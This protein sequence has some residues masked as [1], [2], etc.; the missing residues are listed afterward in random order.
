MQSPLFPTV[1]ECRRFATD[2]YEASMPLRLV[3]DYELDFNL[4]DGRVAIIDGE[5]F[6]LRASSVVLRRP[7]QLAASRGVYNMY[8]LTLGFSG[9]SAQGYSRQTGQTPRERCDFPLLDAIPTYLEPTHASELSAIY[10][11]ILRAFG[12][13]GRERECSILAGELLCLLA[14][15]SLASRTELRDES[16]PIDRIIGYIGEHYAEPVALDDLAGLVHMNK[17][18]LTRL[19]RTRCGRTPIDY[20]IDVRIHSAMKLLEQSSLSVA[21]IAAMSGFSGASYFIERFRR[22]VGVTPAE[23]RRKALT[24]VASR[25][26]I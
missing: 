23:Y 21:R 13:R 22:E 6:T 25:D 20:L 2:L 10:R 17:S 15:D 4:S 24:N 18:Y 26:T 8:L 1:L 11:R 7:G 19:F 12:T 14:A 5:E 9:E 16:D 3:T